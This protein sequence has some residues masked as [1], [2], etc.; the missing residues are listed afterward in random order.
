MQL[1]DLDADLGETKNVQAD[2]P[3]IVASLTKKLETIIANGRSTPGENQANAVPIDL[4]KKGA[5]SKGRAKK[6]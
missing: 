4:W 6:K 5:K 3:E 1:F 2:H